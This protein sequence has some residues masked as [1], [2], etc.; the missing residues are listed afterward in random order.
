MSN[1]LN[2][3]ITGS[4]SEKETIDRINEV[5]EFRGEIGVVSCSDKKF[6]N[7]WYGG[8]KNLE[9]V[10]GIGACGG[11]TTARLAAGMREVEWEEPQS[12]QLFVCE[13]D[14]VVFREID[15][16]NYKGLPNEY[17]RAPNAYTLYLSAYHHELLGL[18]SERQKR[19]PTIVLHHTL[20]SSLDSYASATKHELPEEVLVMR[21]FTVYQDEAGEWRWRLKG[22]NRRILAES[23]EGYETRD[24]C[25]REIQL[26]R[27]LAHMAPVEDEDE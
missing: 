2:V 23:A 13:S 9:M 11:M 10:I 26:V 6:K 15:W 8:D 17:E 4:L 16:S 24:D 22:N 18:I 27:D 21:R 20:V 5:M 14:D 12:V 1:V 25:E 7:P 3:I 19:A